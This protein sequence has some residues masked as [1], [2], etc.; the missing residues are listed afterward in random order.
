MGAECGCVG[1]A[2]WVWVLGEV[3]MNRC[4]LHFCRCEYPYSETEVQAKETRR[5]SKNGQDTLSQY[6]L[7]VLSMHFI[8]V[9]L[10]YS[11]LRFLSH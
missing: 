10:V 11:R 9:H 1:H 7:G 3:A 4:T 5:R 6:H 2:Y 8:Q